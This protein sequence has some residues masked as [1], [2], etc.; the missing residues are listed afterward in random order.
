MNKLQWTPKT[1]H[2]L[3]GSVLLVAALSLSTSPARAQASAASAAA[4]GSDACPPG[5]YCEAAELPPT[6]TK[7]E[8]PPP[9]KAT[10]HALSRPH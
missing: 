10:K 2:G 9:A 6:R 8:T 3:V 7:Q 5:A 1:L 4:S